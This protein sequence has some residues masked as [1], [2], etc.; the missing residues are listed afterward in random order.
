ML[1]QWLSSV[2]PPQPQ[3]GPRRVVA[4]VDPSVADQIDQRLNLPLP[5]S[6][7]RR[8]EAADP[9]GSPSLLPAPHGPRQRLAP[10]EGPRGAEMN[11]SVAAVRGRRRAKPVA[12]GREP[13]RA[14]ARARQGVMSPLATPA[15]ATT[16]PVL[17]VEV[18]GTGVPP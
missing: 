3:L 12:G 15:T 5:P 9:L 1:L 18:G 2:H 4:E 17:Q 10:E 6:R 11:R 13:L 14:P 7:V 8:D 16:V